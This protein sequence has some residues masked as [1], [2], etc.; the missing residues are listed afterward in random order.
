MKWLSRILASPAF[1]WFW[2]FV[3]FA[4]YGGMARNLMDAKTFWTAF[5]LAYAM[6]TWAGYNLGAMKRDKLYRG[7][8]ADLVKANLGMAKVLVEE[9]ICD[10]PVIMDGTAYMGDDDDDDLQPRKD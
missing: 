9:G 4:V 7:I 2:I 8:V 5:V 3:V 6:V 1:A 10:E